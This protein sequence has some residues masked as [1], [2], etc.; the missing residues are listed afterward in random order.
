MVGSSTSW[1]DDAG[2]SFKEVHCSMACGLQ[3]VVL[4]TVPGH[5][6]DPNPTAA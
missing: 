6:S 1:I 5:G 3:M 2:H 4:K